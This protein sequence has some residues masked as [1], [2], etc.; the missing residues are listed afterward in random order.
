MSFIPNKGLVMAGL[1]A[2]LSCT[3][4]AAQTVN[5]GSETCT[6]NYTRTDYYDNGKFNHSYWQPSGMTCFANGGSYNYGDPDGS[7]GE[8]EPIG[9]DRSRY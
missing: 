9:A 2:L 8:G 1:M 5:L 3:S 7:G 6:Q 4:V